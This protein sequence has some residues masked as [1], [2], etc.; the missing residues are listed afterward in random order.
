MKLMIV[1]DHAGMRKM[2]RQLIAAPGDHVLEFGSGEDALQ[3]A[4]EFKPD[5][6]TMDINMPGLCAFKTT[7][8]IRAAHPAARVIF[9]SSHDQPD[10]RRA[11]REVGAVGYVMKD[12]LAELY[13]FV[14]AKRLIISLKV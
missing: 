1:D 11:A 4:A 5:C 6:V 9:V 13:F 14:A 3:A 8:G 12:S 7:E 10:Y 2:I